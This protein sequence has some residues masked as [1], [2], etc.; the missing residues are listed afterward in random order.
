MATRTNWARAKDRTARAAALRAH[1][2][3]LAYERDLR[4]NGTP[5]RSVM[6]KEQMRAETERLTE[7]YFAATFDPWR[8]ANP[9]GRMAAVRCRSC[10]HRANVRVPETC[11]RPHF[12]CARCSSDLVHWRV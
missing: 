11:K 4:Q 1:Y 10:G 7:Q 5:P 2:D 12:R 8:Q 3:N 6:T 9:Q